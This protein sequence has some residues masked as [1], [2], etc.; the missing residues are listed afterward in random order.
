MER[1]YNAT[2]TLSVATEDTKVTK[3]TKAEVVGA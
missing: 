1:D 2:V 3:G